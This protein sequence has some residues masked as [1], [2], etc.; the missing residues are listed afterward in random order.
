[1]EIVKFT[2]F[3]L[4]DILC[5]WLLMSEGTL[6]TFFN[7]WSL[8]K[9]EQ[10]NGYIA[11][12]GGQ[13]KR[14]IWQVSLEIAIKYVTKYIR[15]SYFDQ[16]LNNGYRLICYVCGW[17]QGFKLAYSTPQAITN[18]VC[19][20][21]WLSIQFYLICLAQGCWPQSSK[22][23][24]FPQLRG[25]TLNIESDW[26]VVMVTATGCHVDITTNQSDSRWA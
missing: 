9:P 18:N 15:F 1:M 21:E 4:F 6:D 20:V 7:E 3:T 5:I 10:A 11:K 12:G 23:F 2:G 14:Y 16:I 26:S 25:L 24:F 19:L 8:W 17:A 13:A 22:F